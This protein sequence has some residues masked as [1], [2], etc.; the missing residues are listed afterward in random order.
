MGQQV[1]SVAVGG[2]DVQLGGHRPG[3]ARIGIG[4]RHQFGLRHPTP[5]ILGV[6]FA[7][8]SYAE[9][10][11]IQF[12]HSFFLAGA[13]DPRTMSSPGTLILWFDSDPS[14]MSSRVSIASRPICGIGCRTVVSGGSVYL[15][16]LRSSKPMTEMSSGTRR[17]A[18]RS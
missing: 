17:P 7:H 18:V 11:Y 15:T 10:A 16:I 8:L 1:L 13:V 2:I 9:Y 3:A 5:Q 4:N 12:G 14:R 6:T